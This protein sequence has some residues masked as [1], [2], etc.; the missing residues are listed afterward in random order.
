MANQREILKI[1]DFSGGLNN[2][3]SSTNIKENEASVLTNLKTDKTG[4]LVSI[5]DAEKAVS[6]HNDLPDNN[7]C[8]GMSSL[9]GR[10]IF[11]HGADYRLAD[12][13]SSGAV[14]SG[15][16]LVYHPLP[17]LYA[18][19]I[20]SK[21]NNAWHRGKMAFKSSDG[22]VPQTGKMIPE[23]YIHNGI[24]RVCD[25]DFDNDIV[26]RYHG[27][28]NKRYFLDEEG[29]AY[30]TLEKWQSQEA[31]I[32][33][34][35]ELGCKVQWVST[36]AKN[37]LS[38]TLGDPGTV[39]LGINAVDNSGAWNGQYKLGVSCVYLGQE[40]EITEALKTTSSGSATTDKYI[41]L[42]MASIQIELYL[43]VGTTAIGI[44]NEHILKDDRI[45][46][47]RIYVQR[48]AD[49]NWYMLFETPLET[50]H[51]ATNW[52]HDYDGATDSNNGII[53]SGDISDQTFGSLEGAA[54]HDI[55]MA[56][57]FGT[58]EATM[59]GEVYK[60]KVQGFYQTPMYL[61]FE[62][63]TAQSM[64]VTLPVTNPI[65]NSGSTISQSFK[66]T[67]QNQTGMPLMVKHIEKDITHNDDKPTDYNVQQTEEWGEGYNYEGV[68]RNDLRFQ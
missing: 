24:T 3:A 51:E 53:T 4:S 18:I 42:N 9:T 46:S 65:N 27:Y 1:V 17:S 47:L 22:T 49:E 37:P 36:S 60:L 67:L 66:F 20:H 2:N 21:A 56:I 61:T 63:T 13:D 6:I 23:Y 59:D 35:E 62:K 34:L 19:D 7:G 57:D 58:N 44:A 12:N 33:S 15:E 55:I 40:G 11:G 10:G 28:I 64:N 31:T 50:G 43:T 45:D 52:L 48:E 14:D 38:A 41:Y 5:K 68:N 16:F 39:T 54:R 30:Q 25:S 26:P 8:A 32:K 29:L